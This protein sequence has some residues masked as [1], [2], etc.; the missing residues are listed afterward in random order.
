MLYNWTAYFR[1]TPLKIISLSVSSRRRI[2]NARRPDVKRIL[3]KLMKKHLLQFTFRNR[4]LTV[5]L[6]MYEIRS[7]GNSLRPHGPLSALSDVAPRKHVARPHPI[8]DTA[9]R[10]H[11]QIRHVPARVPIITPIGSATRSRVVWPK[12]GTRRSLGFRIRS[13]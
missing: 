7:N 4:Q 6:M 3:I 8:T 10:T 11:T 9:R 2:V 5:L 13:S 1:E 12:T